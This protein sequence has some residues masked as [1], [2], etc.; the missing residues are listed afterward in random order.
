MALLAD[1]GADRAV[2]LLALTER[3]TALV[4][5]EAAAL[6]EGAPCGP[7]N[8]EFQRLVNVYRLEMGRIQA[9]KSLIAGAPFALRRKLQDAT[10]LLQSELDLYGARLNAARYV[11]EGLLQ[12]IAEETQSAKRT[13]RGYG[14][15]G[16]YA[17]QGAAPLALDKK[18]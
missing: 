3:L 11:A 13:A 4:N 12:A 18:A 16:R 7:S 6:S 5:E 1:D 17:A 10:A 9:D 2:Q 15:Q 14:A 8:E